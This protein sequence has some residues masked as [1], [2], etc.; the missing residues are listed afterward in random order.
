MREGRAKKLIEADLH[1]P[2]S[3]EFDDI[4]EARIVIRDARGCD[5]HRK[6][7]ELV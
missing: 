1:D 3:A 7:Q 2:S 5:V 6:D 4:Q